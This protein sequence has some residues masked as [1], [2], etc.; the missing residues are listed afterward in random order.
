MRLSRVFSEELEA[1]VKQRFSSIEQIDILMLMKRD[2]QRWWSALDVAAALAMAPESA[3]M[4]LFL[5]ASAGSIAMETQGL[6]AYRYL[7]SS[8]TEALL[9]EL[10]IACE[11]KRPAV[12]GLFG[13]GPD[14][15]R[16]F[17]D[18]FRLKG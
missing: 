7:S 6:P 4:R 18:A 17:S 12:V 13:G 15:L 9:D 11:Q 1:F 16:S 3:A 8:Q 10:A 5:L 2:P 14:P